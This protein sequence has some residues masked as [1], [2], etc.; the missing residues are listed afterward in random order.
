M[1]TAERYV[2]TLCKDKTT[3]LAH[4]RKRALERAEQPKAFR[5]L[6]QRV[7]EAVNAYRAAHRSMRKAERIIEGAGFLPPSVD[8]GD[9][10]RLRARGFYEQRSQ[11]NAVFD[12]KVL[13]I[14]A[15]RTKYGLA[16]LGKAPIEAKRLLDR[17]QAELAAL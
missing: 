4:E 16:V 10:P 8:G 14:H 1:T 12:A 13:H 15:L 11:V 17:L 6:P 7:Q 2:S 5:E 9:Q 3:A